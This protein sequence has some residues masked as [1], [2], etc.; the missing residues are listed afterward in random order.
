MIL[1]IILYVLAAFATV[2]LRR[3]SIVGAIAVATSC[4][5]LVALILYVIDRVQTLDNGTARIRTDIAAFTVAISLVVWALTPGFQNK[6]RS[7][8]NGSSILD[9]IDTTTAT[10]RDMS[11]FY[12]STSLFDDNGNLSRYVNDHYL[13]NKREQ[14]IFDRSMA[15]TEM[16]AADLGYVIKVIEEVKDYV[17]ALTPDTKAERSAKQYMSVLK[18]AIRSFLSTRSSSLDAVTKEALE[19]TNDLI[20]RDLIIDNDSTLRVFYDTL[21]PTS[22]HLPRWPQMK[23][24]GNPSARAPNFDPTTF[25]GRGTMPINRA[26]LPYAL[27]MQDTCS[28]A[29][30]ASSSCATLFRKYH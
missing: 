6:S 29:D 30:T 11:Q 7:Y 23:K 2:A 26:S 3:D 15:T 20:R 8:G 10:T 21:E 4:G 25:S 22:P 27:S 5:A 28:T 19:S 13:V 12:L 16:I 14:D 17:Q 24:I 1:Y 18:I 9:E